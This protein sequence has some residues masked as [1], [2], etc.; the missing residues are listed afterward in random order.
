MKFT[1]V[2]YLP[3]WELREMRMS[4][5]AGEAVSLTS[6]FRIPIHHGCLKGLIH[7]GACKTWQDHWSL[8][9]NSELRVTQPSISHCLHV[10]SQKRKCDIILTNWRIGHSH[11]THS[12]I[13]KSKNS[14]LF[15][16][17]NEK[18]RCLSQKFDIVS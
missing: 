3:M 18:E 9:I 6:V 11:L 13:F 5:A 8:L 16:T 7:S 17:K 14:F 15:K 2:S 10:C 1:F 12:L 4:T